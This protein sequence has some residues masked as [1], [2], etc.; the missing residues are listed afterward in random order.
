M[1]VFQIKA[2]L[3]GLFSRKNLIPVIVRLCVFLAGWAKLMIW[4]VPYRVKLLVL[5][6][7]YDTDPPTKRKRKDSVGV[8]VQVLGIYP[9][10]RFR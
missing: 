3:H 5:P 7:P 2:A 10:H 4:V 6:Y 1:P 8:I 9:F